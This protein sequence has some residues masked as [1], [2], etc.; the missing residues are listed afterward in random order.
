MPIELRVEVDYERLRF[1]YRMHGSAW[2]WLPQQFDAYVWYD[3]TTAV[4]PLPTVL[5]LPVVAV[6]ARLGGLADQVEVERHAVL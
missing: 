1:A 6:N 4:T 5:D 2:Q 3:E